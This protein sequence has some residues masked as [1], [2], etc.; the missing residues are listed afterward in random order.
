MVCPKKNCDKLEPSPVFLLQRTT[1]VCPVELET[2]ESA[3]T[4]TK[5]LQNLQNYGNYS[6]F[7]SLSGYD[8]IVS[9]LGIPSSHVDQCLRQVAALYLNK[10]ISVMGTVGSIVFIVLFESTIVIIDNYV[11]MLEPTLWP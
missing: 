2:K 9:E 8:D 7:L 6:R 3:N 1:S 5:V 11:E 10:C 4:A